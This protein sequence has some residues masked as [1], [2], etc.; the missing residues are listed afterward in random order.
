MKPSRYD[1]HG[2]DVLRFTPEYVEYDSGG[3]HTKTTWERM[4]EGPMR[5]GGDRKGGIS[6]CSD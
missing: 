4:S 6:L 2:T 5:V 3:W 1:L